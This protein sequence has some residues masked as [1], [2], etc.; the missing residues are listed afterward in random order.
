MTDPI[1]PS[2]NH[3]YVCTN[4]TMKENITGNTIH[5]LLPR[6]CR[7]TFIIRYLLVFVKKN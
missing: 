6:P 4:D 7:E 5:C 1:T 2:S 3:K